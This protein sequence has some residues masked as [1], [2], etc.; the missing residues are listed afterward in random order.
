MCRSWIFLKSLLEF[1]S[2]DFLRCHIVLNVHD[3]VDLSQEGHIQPHANIQLNL[4]RRKK[5]PC[6]SVLWKHGCM[7]ACSSDWLCVLYEAPVTQKKTLGFSLPCFPYCIWQDRDHK[8]QSFHQLKL[9]PLRKCCAIDPWASLSASS[10]EITHE[11]VV[12]LSRA[13]KVIGIGA[14]I[15]TRHEVMR[16]TI[17]MHH[18]QF[19]SLANHQGREKLIT[20]G[21][22]SWRQPGDI[23]LWT[24]VS[25][26][27]ITV[28]LINSLPESLPGEQE[29]RDSY[30]LMM[31]VSCNSVALNFCSD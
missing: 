3:N 22:V 23:Y 20:L 29:F 16:G 26:L 28:P 18:P 7:I 15:Q 1:V 11:Y 9:R 6:F 14:V 5:L 19:E 30:R 17:M 31:L 21:A 10:A 24:H 8:P 13:R 2:L 27:A 12:H 4:F 25:N